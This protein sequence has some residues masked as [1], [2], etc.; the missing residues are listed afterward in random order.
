MK[1]RLL[2]VLLAA[3]MVLS[4]CPVSAFADYTG[5]GGRLLTR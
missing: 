5:G 1:K 3:S 2:S 4:L